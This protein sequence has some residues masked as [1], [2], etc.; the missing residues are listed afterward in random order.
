MCLSLRTAAATASIV[1]SLLL[2]EPAQ[3]VPYQVLIDTM[4]LSGTQA[5]LALDVLDG[6]PPANAIAISSF[7]TDGTLGNTSSLGDVTG[8]LPGP[9]TLGDGS[10]FNE[11]LADLTL[12]TSLAFIFTPTG[13]APDAA[14]LPDAFTVFLLDPLSGLPLF[15]TTDPTG[16]NALFQYDIDGTT[17]GS[18]RV[19]EASKQEIT[20]SIE[21]A[22]QSV[23]EPATWTL[24][25]LAAL[26]AA[27]RW[28]RHSGTGAP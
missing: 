9:V 13:S 6:G 18:L 4:G 5:Q 24:L 12:G 17:L 28:R 10:F 27:P 20:L 11:H 3:A 14:S 8:T 2:A 16:A 26:A 15:A 1:I 19:F 7:S 21:Q 25:L 23:P 22:R